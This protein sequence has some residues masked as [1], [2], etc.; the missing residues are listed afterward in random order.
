[1]RKIVEEPIVRGEYGF[2]TNK[3]WG[4]FLNTFEDIECVPSEIWQQALKKE[5]I[6]TSCLMFEDEAPEEL[7]VDYF[8]TPHWDL[9]LW[10]W[11]PTPLND[12]W[13]LV[14]IHDTDDGPCAVFVKYIV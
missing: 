1:M 7:V 5:G 3:S 6:M 14:S 10:Q 13:F 11:E 9:A 12:D 8:E 2:F 4:D